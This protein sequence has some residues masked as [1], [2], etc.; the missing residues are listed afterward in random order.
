MIYA[1]QGI[2]QKNA[3]ED[4]HYHCELNTPN[5]EA[6]FLFMSLYMMYLNKAMLKF[7]SGSTVSA[8][9]INVDASVITANMGDSPIIALRNNEQHILL[10]DDH[11]IPDKQNEN[12]DIQ[13]I[14]EMKKGMVYQHPKS[15]KNYIVNPRAETFDGISM[16]RALGDSDMRDCLVRHPVI[17]T[18][19]LFEYGKERWAPHAIVKEKPV[20][21][22][23]VMSD[24]CIE[25]GY[26]WLPVVETF[27]NAEDAAQKFMGLKCIDVEMGEQY[28]NYTAMF[29]D[30]NVKKPLFMAVFD[31][32]NG[33]D[34]AEA[35]RVFTEEF[36]S[37]YNKNGIQMSF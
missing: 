31:G 1:Y 7:K 36:C 8:A 20:T 3:Q 30:L 22:I 37:D 27:R 12:P 18:H 11:S 10:H 16:T 34:C 17:L 9:L 29:A 33:F 24:G 5:T 26:E 23:A 6:G 35:A 13:N 28:D 32:H 25:R 19:D 15:G 14:C 4:R 21:V 2:G